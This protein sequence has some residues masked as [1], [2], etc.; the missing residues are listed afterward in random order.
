M[1]LQLEFKELDL[2][3]WL[4]VQNRLWIV[5]FSLQS[6]G[7]VTSKKTRHDGYWEFYRKSLLDSSSQRQSKAAFLE[8]G[9]LLFICN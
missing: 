5:K 8:G 2:K 3:I 9:Y 4:Q 6:W 1:F 7:F